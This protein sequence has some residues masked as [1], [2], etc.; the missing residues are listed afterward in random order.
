MYY[1]K[2]EDNNWLVGS[3]VSFP[4][5]VTISVDNKIDKD[6]WFWSD[7]IPTEYTEWLESNEE[8]D[9]V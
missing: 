9:L 8:E 1:K 7:E 2:D 4:D 5:G 3:K 6:G